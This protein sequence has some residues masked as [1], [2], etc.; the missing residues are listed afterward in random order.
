[1]IALFQ[2]QNPDLV[3][4]IVDNEIRSI[5]AGLNRA[6]Q[7]ARGEIIV[8]LDAH[9]MPYPDYVARCVQALNDGKGENVGGVWEVK[10]GAQTL[11]AGSIAAAA[12]HPLGVGDAMY[13]LTPQAGSVDTV[14][15]GSFRRSLI[16]EIGQYDESLLSNEDYEFNARLRRSGGK[17]WLDPQIRSVY[18]ARP[19]LNA[20]AQQYWRYGYWKW[21]MLRRYP[22]TIR[23]R[24]ALPPLFVLSLTLFAILSIWFRWAGLAVLA[25]LSVYFIILFMA[26][27]SMAIRQRLWGLIV[28]LPPAI[29]IMHLAW[30]GGF[31][32]S[33]MSR[34]L[35]K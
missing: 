5:P 9:S 13:R 26:A 3:I 34:P 20:L 25:E 2:A 31:L 35:N 15:F 29:F 28:G 22:S 19:T 17:I 21:Q 8:R 7:A 27:A 16:E 30:G 1:V 24:Q 23:W 12:A 18:F 10:P 11:I 33:M 6:L 14:P 32:W 4:R